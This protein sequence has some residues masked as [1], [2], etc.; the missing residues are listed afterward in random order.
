MTERIAQH[1]EC[2]IQYV[3]QQPYHFSYCSVTCYPNGAMVPE[4]TS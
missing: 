2:K 1:P 3:E 4:K